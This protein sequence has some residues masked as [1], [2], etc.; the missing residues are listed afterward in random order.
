MAVIAW[1]PDDDESTPSPN[2][3]PFSTAD[4][5][6][7]IRGKTMSS[8]GNGASCGCG[9]GGGT[10]NGNAFDF[11]TYTLVNIGSYEVTIEMRINVGGKLL[12]FKCDPKIIV[13][14]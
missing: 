2:D 11:G 12:E 9:V 14:T 13:G 10:Q 3:S 7:M 1:R 4:F 6:E 5:D 8:V